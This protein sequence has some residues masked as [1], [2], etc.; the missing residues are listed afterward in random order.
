MDERVVTVILP[1]AGVGARFAAAYPKELHSVMPG[2]AVVDRAVE[3]VTGLV[4]QGL[5]VRLVVVIGPHKLATVGY[6]HKYAEL[7]EVVFVYQSERRGPGLGGA[8]RA[9]LPL[10]VGDVVLLL[11]DQVLRGEGAETALPR[12][13]EALA[14]SDWAVVAA[15]IADSAQLADEGALR[16]ESGRV[17][18]AREKPGAAAAE[19]FDAAWAVIAVRGACATELPAAVDPDADSPLVGAPAVL[20]S[21]FDNVTSAPAWGGCCAE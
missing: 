17:R 9:A 10:C 5:R 15:P 20:V 4:E 8:I 18:A 1:C 13:V 19:A 21:A 3:P 11:P 16:L 2:V 7:F 14:N 12:A 6:L